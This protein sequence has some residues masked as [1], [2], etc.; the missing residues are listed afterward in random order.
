[1]HRYAVLCEVLFSVQSLVL[2]V[3][4][5]FHVPKIIT[6]PITTSITDA[7]AAAFRVGAQTR[8]LYCSAS[9]ALRNT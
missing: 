9:K 1:M 8:S 2:T 6:T 7:A 5:L 3:C 4:V